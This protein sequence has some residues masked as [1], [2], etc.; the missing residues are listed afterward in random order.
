MGRQRPE[1][2]A[3]KI[4][5]SHAKLSAP[6]SG[7]DGTLSRWKTYPNG[8]NFPNVTAIT[9]K[10]PAFPSNAPG[11]YGRKIKFRYRTNSLKGDRRSALPEGTMPFKGLFVATPQIE[12]NSTAPTRPT[13]QT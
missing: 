7:I 2:G 13:P 12:R 11:K 10:A 6:A 5:K 8:R 4:L 1:R 3:G 9:E